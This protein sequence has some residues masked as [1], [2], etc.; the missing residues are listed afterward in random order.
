MKRQPYFS[1]RFLLS[2]CLIIVADSWA[3]IKA[4][5]LT[6]NTNDVRSKWKVP[7]VGLGAVMRN[8][9]WLLTE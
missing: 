9:C 6:N 5:Q 8:E 4:L 2:L 7:K 1:T 3:L